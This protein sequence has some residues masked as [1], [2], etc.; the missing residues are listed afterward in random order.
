VLGAYKLFVCFIPVLVI[1]VVLHCTI[2][3]VLTGTEDVPFKMCQNSV[4][5]IGHFE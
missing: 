2:I 5:I 4:V 1:V 3:T